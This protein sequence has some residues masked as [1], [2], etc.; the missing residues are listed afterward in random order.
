MT[1]PTGPGPT[2]QPSAQSPADADPLESRRRRALF[3][4]TH[5]GSH[6]NDILIGGFLA[7]RIVAFDAAELDGLEVLLDLPDPDLNDFLLG[8]R[9]IPPE[10]DSPLLRAM[11]DAAHR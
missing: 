6:E 11:K 7:A 8:R 9:P 1:R 3:R 5:R 10:L 2:G 4:A